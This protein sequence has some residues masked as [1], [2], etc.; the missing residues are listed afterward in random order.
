MKEKRVVQTEDVNAEW[1]QSIG[2]DKLNPFERID[3]LEKAGKFD[4]GV[5]DD[6]ITYELLP[7]Q[8][9]YEQKKLWTKV[10]SK[11]ANTL[12]QIGINGF[13]KKGMFAIKEIK[14]LENWQNIKTGAILTCNHFSPNDSFVTQKVLKASK[15]KKLYRVVL[16]G[17]YTNPPMLKF[18]MRNC[19]VLPLSSNSQTM[20]KFMRAIDNILKR[21]DNILI[22]PESC[23]WLDYRKP[24][25][26]K[27]GGFRFAVKNNVP[28][29]PMFI[30]MEDGEFYDKKSKQ[31]KPMP[32]YTVHILKPIYT[33]E[34]LS[35]KENIEYVKNENYNRWV[36]VYESVYGKKLEYTT[37]K[38]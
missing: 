21:G 3:A 2:W 5:L 7:N 1:K 36:E 13:M 30:T 14:G 28:V 11:I 27:D 17:N 22:Y 31:N 12:S 25:P 8:I 9:D 38:D 24:R 6:P 32:V 10:K 4:V 23:M 35:S 20:R 15:K 18:F 33:K 26:L 16:E 29:V 19:D 37:D 34:D